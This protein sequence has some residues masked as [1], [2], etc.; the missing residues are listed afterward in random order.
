MIPTP[1]YLLEDA[2][3]SGSLLANLKQNFYVLQIQHCHRPIAT[4]QIFTH[5]HS[6][7]PPLDSHSF[8]PYYYPLNRCWIARLHQKSPYSITAIRA[9]LNGPGLRPAH[10]GSCG[11]VWA[12]QQVDKNKKSV[13]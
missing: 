6:S 9:A 12:G 11:L 3:T 4:Q 7:Y 8:Y 13:E 1:Y 10:I 2:D 5:V